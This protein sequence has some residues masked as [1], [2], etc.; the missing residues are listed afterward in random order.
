ML[1]AFEKE[2]VQIRFIS[3]VPGSVNLNNLFS[4]F[5]PFGDVFF[6][7]SLSQRG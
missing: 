1:E 6:Y 4:P 2:E 7:V 3:H 5:F